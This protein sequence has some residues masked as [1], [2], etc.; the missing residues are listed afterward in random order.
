MTTSLLASLRPV[1]L[2]QAL[3]SREQIPEQG[4]RGGRQ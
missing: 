4:P 2:Q 1:S 3:R